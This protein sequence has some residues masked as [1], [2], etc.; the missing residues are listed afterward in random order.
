[1]RY[2]SGLE[3]ALSLAKPAKSR[4]LAL[5]SPTKVGLAPA[6]GSLMNQAG[7]TS[8]HSSGVV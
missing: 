4:L 5:G 1:M 6:V 7:V 3:A 2:N 8:V